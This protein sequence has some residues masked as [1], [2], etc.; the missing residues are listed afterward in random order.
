MQG[1]DWRHGHGAKEPAG[2]QRRAKPYA[3]ARWVARGLLAVVLGGGLAV[4]PWVG[5]A[6]ENKPP[7]ANLKLR[8]RQ[9]EPHWVE[10][11]ASRARDKDGG[12]L[13]YRFWVTEEESGVVVREPLLTGEPHQ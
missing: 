8:K 3:W 11:D 6:E 10:V 9:A 12:L 5:Q 7:E 1:H 13:H 2:E 4:G